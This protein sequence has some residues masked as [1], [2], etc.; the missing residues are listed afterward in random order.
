MDPGVLEQTL[1]D[2]IERGHLPPGTPLKQEELAARFGVSRQPVR[3]VLERLLAASL[4]TRMP[5]RTVAV[6]EWNPKQARDLIGVRIALETEALRLSLPHLDDATIRKAR[7]V[8][9]V[10]LD[11]EEAEEIERL[12]VRF[13]NLLYGFCGNDRLGKMIEDLRREGRRIYSMQ[14]RQ[15]QVRT[16]LFEEHQAILAA[17]ENRDAKRAVDA[18]SRHLANTIKHIGDER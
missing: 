2:E 6:S 13:H 14:P 16:A 18:L 5:D 9:E 7:R 10:L 3:A 17:C 8:S 15:S 12:D 11:E 4:L 1:R